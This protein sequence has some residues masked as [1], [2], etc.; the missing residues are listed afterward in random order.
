MANFGKLNFST[1][2]NPTSA[3]PLDARCYFTSLASAEAAA[4]IAEEAGSTNSIYYYGMKLLVDDGVEP[5]WYTIQ[6]D[7]TLLEEGQNGGYVAQD[8]PPEDTTLLWLDTSDDSG[9]APDV[10]TDD[11]GKIIQ[12]VDGVWTAVPVSESNI[13]KYIDEYINNALGGEY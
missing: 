6:R 10:T 4:A 2:F 5:L 7:G 9:S 13:G 8:T 1:S 11:D 3:F 12:V